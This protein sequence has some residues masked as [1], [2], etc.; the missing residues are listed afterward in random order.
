MEAIHRR[1]R[2]RPPAIA[3]VARRQ[4]HHAPADDDTAP[5]AQ[6]AATASRSVRGRRRSCG[7]LT[8][9][10][11]PVGGPPAWPRRRGAACR[12]RAR[13]NY[14]RDERPRDDR[15]NQATCGSRR[16]TTP[17]A[18]GRSFPASPAAR[19]PPLG[20]GSATPAPT[21]TVSAH[22]G[23]GNPMQTSPSR[24]A[25]RDQTSSTSTSTARSATASPPTASSPRPALLDGTLTI[26]TTPS[27]GLHLYF[28]GT[29][30]PSGRLIRHHL[31][32]KATGGYVLAPPSQ[33]DGQTVPAAHRAT[34]QPG[35]LDWTPVT[36]CWN[37][38]ASSRSGTEAA[39]LADPAR[40][41]AL[42]G[43]AG[44]RQ[45]QQRPVLGRL[46]SHRIRPGTPPRRPGRSRRHGLPDREITRTISSARRSA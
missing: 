29:G 19:N 34:H 42:G 8:T 31:D 11:L 30:Q 41:T 20:T 13:P 7:G 12:C 14:I 37:L 26:V 38:S 44:G 45:P 39:V 18:A 9:F 15:P 6:R 24:P 10:H 16:S 22:G 3:D 36:A 28:T 33:V 32:F 25:R 35:V 43:A 46:P 2:S 5:A 17:C 21:L 27:G 1:R 40:L 23:V 4:R